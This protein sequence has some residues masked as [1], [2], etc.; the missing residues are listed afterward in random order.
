FAMHPESS[1]PV[2]AV[3][4]TLGPDGADAEVRDLRQPD[5]AYT[6]PFAPPA[7][8]PVPVA[9]PVTLALAAGEP[10]CDGALTLTATAEGGTGTGYTFIWEIDGRAV[11][12]A[13]ATEGAISTLAYT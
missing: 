8:T 11:A 3:V 9:P 1:A 5:H 4:V 7:P 2:S 13:P 12:N 6:A 10:G